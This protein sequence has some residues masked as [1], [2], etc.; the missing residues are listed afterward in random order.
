[1]FA[2]NQPWKNT[3]LES[4]DQRTEKRQGEKTVMMEAEC[5]RKLVGDFRQR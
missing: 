2:A 4:N 3:H 5:R 1:M